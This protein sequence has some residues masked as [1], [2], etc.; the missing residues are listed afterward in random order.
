MSQG[1]NKWIGKGNLGADP[2]LRVTQG[3]QSVLKLRMAC[4][5]SYVD[6]N[7][8]KQEKTEWV[9]VT[10]WGKRAEGLAKFL[11]KG[12]EILVEGRLQTSSYE[13]DGQKRY[14]TEVVANDIRFC[15]GKRDSAP[16]PA[17]SNDDDLP[18]VALDDSEIPF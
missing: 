11:Q 9:S 16:A 10:V 1:Y 8:V 14:S 12:S 6:K 5:E 17:D 13:K 2:E 7:N 4:N 3:G 18:V 15:G